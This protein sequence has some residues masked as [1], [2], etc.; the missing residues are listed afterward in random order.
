MKQSVWLMLLL[1]SVVVGVGYTV[2]FLAGDGRAVAAPPLTL[3][4]E[5]LKEG[6]PEATMKEK[7]DVDNSACYVC[8]GNYDGEALVVAH[9]KE[10]TGC[11][12]CHGKSIEHRND[13]DNIT[14]PDKMYALDDVD[15]MCAKCHDEHDVSARKILRRWQKRCPAKTD[16][17]EIVCT[18]C[19]YQHRLAFRTVWW[20]KKT[21][22]LIIRKEGERTK[23]AADVT[24]MGTKAAAGK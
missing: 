4:P 9:G 13:E 5:L 24:G 10:G 20:D 21:G 1:A 8:H 23:P 22:R 12:D 7:L 19:H 3:S 18:D 6:L 15:A 2:G 16:P 14:P 17:E 11:M